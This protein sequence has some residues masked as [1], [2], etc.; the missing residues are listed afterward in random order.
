[1]PTVRL[2]EAQPDEPLQ[3]VE[4]SG[5]RRR[6]LLITPGQGS[7]GFYPAEVLERDAATAFPA[8]THL[9]LDHPGDTEAAD[10][11]RVGRSVR[12]LAGVLETAGA[13]DRSGPEGAGV[14]ATATIAEGYAP[15]IDDLA[16]HIGLSVRGTGVAEDGERDGRRTRIVTALHACESVDFVT[17]A[18]RGG[19]VLELVESLR[20]T[21]ESAEL[22]EARAR[23]EEARN[24]GQWHESHLHLA[25]TERADHAAAEGRLTRDER[26]ALSSAIGEALDAFGAALMREAP[27]LY[28]R[29]PYDQPDPATPPTIQEAHVA[30]PA[31]LEAQVSELTN[32]ISALEADNASVIA[33][34]DEARTDL[35]RRQDADRL[36]DEQTAVTEAVAAV[37]IPQGLESVAE[38]IR[39]R[40]ARQVA[41]TRDTDDVIVREALNEAARTAVTAEVEYLGQAPG[42]RVVGLGESTTPPADGD[43]L[44]AQL[45]TILAESFGRPTTTRS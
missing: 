29:D 7:S 34:R 32:R 28:E 30:T 36:R 38:S 20:E 2:D 45:N 25:F 43:D 39:Q 14:Y 3:L 42:A 10:R 27:H 6:M 22:A 11:V 23:V 18:G 16:P 1:M 21:P 4:A 13:Y 24:V 17:R 37:D 35:Q 15:L 44:D 33:E 40:A 31:E 41:V 19:R 12:D 5:S 8:G 26:I 9:Y